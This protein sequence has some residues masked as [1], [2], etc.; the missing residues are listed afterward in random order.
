[1]TTKTTTTSESHTTEVDGVL[2]TI[3]TITFLPSYKPTVQK[4]T[5]T[6]VEVKPEAVVTQKAET[7]KWL[8]ET[9][10][11]LT[12]QKVYGDK[13]SY[14]RA[15][16]NNELLAATDTNFYVYVMSKGEEQRNI[17]YTAESL[18]Y[19]I[20]VLTGTPKE[21]LADYTKAL[22]RV[23]KG[24][25]RPIAIFY[26]RAEDTMYKPTERAKSNHTSVLDKNKK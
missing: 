6:V 14:G 3:T 13:I 21:V 24:V 22:K 4:T 26:Y 17:K 2:T 1:M 25:E 7:T 11:R 5:P 12:K 20:L 18:G 19:E 9:Q 15:T 16:L 8:K 10:A 23:E